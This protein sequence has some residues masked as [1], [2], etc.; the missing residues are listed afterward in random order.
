MKN[1]FEQENQGFTSIETPKWERFIQPQNPEQPLIRINRNEKEA[2]FDAVFAIELAGVVRK[3]SEAPKSNNKEDKRNEGVI[4]CYSNLLMSS[5]ADDQGLEFVYSG[6]GNGNAKTCLSWKIVG[7]SKGDSF[8]EAATAIDRLWE[9]ITV[10]TGSV[11]NNYT[12]MPV[13]E[14]GRLRDET[15]EG[16]IG[17][18]RPLGISINTD[19]ARPLGFI[20]EAKSG[21]TA[22]SMLIIPWNASKEGK[23]FDPVATAFAGCPSEVTV[24]LSFKRF[25]LSEDELRTVTS[26]LR[27]LRNGEAKGITY[28]PEIRGGSYNEDL[29][30]NLESALELW[31]KNPCGL[32]VNCTAI[33]KKPIP[34]SFLSLAG[35]VIFKGAPF[36][37]S[38][39]KHGAAGNGNNSEQ[40]VLDLQECF[41]DADALPSVF[42]SVAALLDCNVKRSFPQAVFDTP[43]DGIILG[44]VGHGAALKDVHFSGTDRGRHCYI[45]GA[46]GTGKSTLLYNMIRQDIENGEGVTLL[47][48]HGDLYQEVL[49]S[50]PEKRMDD[51]V[52]VDPCDFDYSP[53]INFLECNG[54]HRAVQM[55]FVANEMIKIFDRLY[56]M[57]S[58]GGPIFEQYM[59]NALLLIMD[60]DYPGATLMDLPL[61]FEDEDYRKFLKKGCKNPIVKDFWEHQAERAAGDASLKSLAPYITSKLNQFTTNALIRPIIG[62]SKST[63][64]FKDVLD[65]RKILLINLSKGYLGEL[66]T[67][68]LGMLI[69]GKLFSSAMSRV[70]LRPE[71]RK[72][73]FLYIDELQNFTTNSISFMLSEARKFGLSLVL[74]N[75]NMSQINSHN[76][77][78]SVLGNVGSMLLFRMGAMDAEKMATYT[79][80]ELQMHDLQELPD[81]H[82]AA[83]LLHK[84]VPSRSFVFKT[85]PLMIPVGSVPKDAIISASRLKYALPTEKVEN[86]IL[87]RRTEYKDGTPKEGM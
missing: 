1:S 4:D 74:A 38:M 23:V 77:L 18:V 69:V 22:S 49:S 62:Q 65:N 86:H 66:D 55:N 76:I 36:S 21:A 70:A 7:R 42:P 81:F 63:F 6:G 71:D 13:V 84:N 53:G 56:D 29:I 52:L 78:D 64:N 30:K 80:P 48:P 50:I 57:R 10:V 28:H 67:Q 26:A 59:R 75:Q 15:S 5:V 40:R 33:S 60:N 41:N 27:W 45:I 73:M 2:C 14:P 37:V 34:S 39:E 58:A 25:K 44:N 46:T 72:P 19:S 8:E 17:T 61:L 32:R 20:H 35:S 9:N 16:W 87:A 85:K 83:R 31:I 82:V 24:A 68:L 79:R 47:D 43:S 12:F 54:P 3:E 11:R 51:V